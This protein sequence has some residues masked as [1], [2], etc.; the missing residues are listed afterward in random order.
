MIKSH[1]GIEA[2]WYRRFRH[3][4]WMVVCTLKVSENSWLTDNNDFSSIKSI[5]LKIYY[6]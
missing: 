4:L 1:R 2:C 6:T 3:L 5:T